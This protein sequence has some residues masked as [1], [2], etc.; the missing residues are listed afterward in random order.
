MA[1]SMTDMM[2][3]TVREIGKYQTELSDMQT[4]MTKGVKILS[5]EDDPLAFARMQSLENQI[6]EIDSYETSA[7]LANMRINLGDR[8][9]EGSLDAMQ[10][11]RELGIQAISDTQTEESRLAIAI[12]SRGIIDRMANLVNTQDAAGEYLF[13]GDDVESVPFNV[14]RDPVT[15]KV[16]K[17]EY[18]GSHETNRVAKIGMDD[19]SATALGS[20]RIPLSM[21]GSQ[22]VSGGENHYADEK[23]YLPVPKYP[24]PEGFHDYDPKMAHLASGY[25]QYLAHTYAASNP[26][27]QDY[28]LSS[29]AYDAP[30]DLAYKYSHPNSPDYDVNNATY[31]NAGLDT[32]IRGEIRDAV[33]N[34]MSE[35]YDTSSGYYDETLETQYK[36]SHPMSEGYDPLSPNYSPAIDGKVTNEIR[37]IVSDP[38]APSY[39]TSNL[40]YDIG[41][42]AALD[43][44]NP[45]SPNY[46]PANPNFDA[47]VRDKHVIDASNFYSLGYNPDSAYY[48]KTMEEEIVNAEVFKVSDALSPHYDPTSTLYSADVE[49]GVQAFRDFVV[50]NTSNPFSDFYDPLSADFDSNTEDKYRASHPL[51]ASYDKTSAD[52]DEN[53]DPNSEF[54]IAVDNAYDPAQAFG[55][56]REKIEFENMNAQEADVFTTMILMSERLENGQSVTKSL[57]NID[58]G[59]RSLSNT[60]S[61]IGSYLGTIETQMTINENFSLEMKESLSDLKDLDMAEAIMEFQSKMLALQMA[62]QAFAK[63][64]ELSQQFQSIF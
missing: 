16:V 23:S 41:R 11:F 5:A 53:L 48:D 30:T 15:Q 19:G 27:S 32:Q 47:A 61:S 28:D 59:I 64:K 33:S 37:D 38:N 44:S 46:N 39:D 22:I 6:R 57:D 14:I 20:T 25:N 63:I 36:A 55:T 52:Y 2:N 50:S 31:Y 10:R 1:V 13:G 58:D 29:A 56:S 51:S 18:Q 43:V 35:Y 7:N 26:Y 49:T 62:Q 4:K 12:E 8:S 3:N 40:Y 9:V 24:T 45:D 42:E 54:Y 60:R 34:P 21:D 17:V